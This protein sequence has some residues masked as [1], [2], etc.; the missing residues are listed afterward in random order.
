MK[1]ETKQ[2]IRMCEERGYMV[3][4]SGGGHLKVKNATGGTV[5]TLPSSPS[6]PRS[7]RNTIRD[8]KRAGVLS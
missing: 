3:V 2:L 8:L 1:R 5:A 6:C 4:L 7:Y